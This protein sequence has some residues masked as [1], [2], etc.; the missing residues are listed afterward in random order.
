MRAF[1]DTV[2]K[3]DQT[4]FAALDKVNKLRKKP[5]FRAQVEEAVKD[6]RAPQQAIAF[7]A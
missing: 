3:L 4:A 1:W 7:D 2:E 5:T 6:V